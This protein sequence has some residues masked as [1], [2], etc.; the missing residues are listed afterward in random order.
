MAGLPL[1]VVA[2]AGERWLGL[3]SD[4]DAPLNCQAE[5][6]GQTA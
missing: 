4:T 5:Y 3:A 6:D 2:G 1:V